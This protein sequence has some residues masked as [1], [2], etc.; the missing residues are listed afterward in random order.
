MDLPKV[1]IIFDIKI[2]Q[3]DFSTLKVN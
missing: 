1:K 3:F 2:K